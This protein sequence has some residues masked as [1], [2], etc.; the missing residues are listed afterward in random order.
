MNQ[1]KKT[2]VWVSTLEE[3]NFIISPK[4]GTMENFADVT[5]HVRSLPNQYC[6]TEEELKELLCKTF[7]AGIDSALFGYSS[8]KMVTYIDNLFKPTTNE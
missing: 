8:P 2:D 1:L 7:D 6:F 4:Q 5:C 3:T